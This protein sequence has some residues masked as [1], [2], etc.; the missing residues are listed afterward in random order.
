MF[1]SRV[2]VANG[3]LQRRSQSTNPGAS[4]VP[5][6]LS[7]GAGAQQ[8]APHKV[9]A[10]VD[11]GMTSVGMFG[12]VQFS[13]MFRGIIPDNSSDDSQ[14]GT[15]LRDIWHYDNVGGSAVDLQCGLAFSN[16]TLTGA[17][18]EVSE[19]YADALARLDMRIMLPQISRNFLVDGAFIGTLLFDP[20]TN[21]FQD[22]LVHDRFNATISPQPLFAVDP[23]VVVNSANN[24]KQFMASYS[25]YADMT[26]RGYPRKIL[27]NFMNGSNVLDP[28]T[29]LMALRKGTQ[30][31]ACVSYL[32]R[33]LPM[34]MLEKTLFRGTLTEASKR[35]RA[36]TQIVMGSDTWEPTVQ[37]MMEYTQKF[38]M[39][40]MDPL[41]AWVATRQGV[42]LNDIRPAGEIWKWTD[43]AD[44]LVPYKLRALGISEAFL[45]SDA[46]MVG[47]TLIP[48]DK[49]LVT[50]ESLGIGRK[51]N[52]VQAISVTT[53]SRYGQGKATGWLYN[54][55]RDTIKVTTD[56]GHG[57]QATG[58]HP[59]LVL[60]GGKTDWV[61]TDK[62]VLGD[63][64]VM[65][66]TKM[67]RT[68]KLALNI[69]PWTPA[70]RKT[71]AKDGK[72]T[73]CNPNSRWNDD[74]YDQSKFPKVMTPKLAYWLS[75]FI[76]EGY[77]TINANFA[78]SDK[79]LVSRFATLGAE[80][81]GCAVPDIYVKY[82][83]E[84]K[85]T[86]IYGV[87][88]RSTKDYYITR[89]C[90]LALMDWLKKVGVS[91]NKHADCD[92][93][94][95]SYYKEV[96]WSVLQSDEESQRA[97]LAGYAECDGVVD[98]RTLWITV[99][100][101]LA[102]QIRSMLSAHGYSPRGSVG[103]DTPGKDS[104]A[105]RVCLGSVDANDFWAKASKYLSSKTFTPVEGA[106]Q[107]IAGMPVDYWFNKV[108]AAKAGFNRHGQQFVANGKTVLWVNEFWGNTKVRAVNWDCKRIQYADY[109]AGRYDSFMALLKELFPEDHAGLVALLKQEYKYT[110]VVSLGAGGKQHVYDI[111]MKEGTEPAFV[112]N[113]LIVHN[114]YA[115][116]EA[117]LTMF[118]DNLDGY[119]EYMTHK[120]FYSKLFPLI[121][122]TNGLYKEP[123]EVKDRGSLDSLLFNMK[124]TKNL[125][126]PTIQWQKNLKT[127]NS[128]VLLENLEKLS[129]KGFPVGLKTWAAAANIDLS[130]SLF[131][132]AQDKE[133]RDKI[134]QLT[135]KPQ[136]DGI[137]PPGGEDSGEDSGEDVESS[138]TLD[139]FRR[140][141]DS[142]PMKSALRT[143]TPS[144][145]DREFGGDFKYNKSGKPIPASASESRAANDKI[146]KAAQALKDP[147]RFA[148][149]RKQVIARNGG[150]MPRVGW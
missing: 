150:G 147:H 100:D 125:R 75:L 140:H 132:L 88:T 25:P 117:S 138:M 141:V 137:R 98:S 79:K 6:Y 87:K 133:I 84:H 26:L 80:L 107:K 48:T 16:W 128:S 58:N 149:V 134:A 24:L 148:E 66:P 144:L 10:S 146:I 90:S 103:D 92:G 108:S 70:P 135:G 11:G 121:A 95:P 39:S 81:F 44:V 131:D 42:A 53:A 9:S 126:M 7:K 12:G 139:A 122:I 56:T 62:L 142:Y 86:E 143:P 63:T 118:M 51:R 4:S 78:N 47:E 94:T 99:S 41:G 31:S 124:N 50:I 102:N 32:R 105:Y 21:G 60:R 145:L 74:Y 8:P 22:V 97:F 57:I 136:D 114:T 89:F 115:N 106:Y 77:G 29:T 20:Q 15:L 35:Q 93:K 43:S 72:G 101:K 111:S 27:E 54:G 34:Y 109:K 49:G 38:Q 96:P 30:D 91:I 67:V 1:K 129:E 85:D 36:T 52:D 73:G 83:D 19:V 61:R 45:S 33:L 28:V 46:C 5:Q 3:V 104:R 55:F 14:L 13:T 65:S 130:S 76:S 59:V 123:K 23:V 116:A 64:M 2:S 127:P 119:R 113:G 110:D 71:V 68:T 18:Q 17:D 82:A 112:A 37:E 120:L 69:A 40:D